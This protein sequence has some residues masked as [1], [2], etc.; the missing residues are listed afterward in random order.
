LCGN[1]VVEKLLILARELDLQNE[2]DEVQPKLIP[3]IYEG[4]VAD[5]CTKLKD[6]IYSKIKADQ[7]PN[8]VL[9]YW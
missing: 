3:N 6:P 2:F 1:D 4:N 8:H 7:E 9:R 5:F